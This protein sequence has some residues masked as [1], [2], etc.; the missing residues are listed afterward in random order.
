MDQHPPFGTFTPPLFLK[1]LLFITRHTLLGRGQV[2]RKT[3]LAFKYHSFDCYDL[4]VRNYFMR[5]YPGNNTVERKLML[6]PDRYCPDEIKFLRQVFKGATA[7]EPMS[8]LDI[9]ANIGALTLPVA[10]LPNV[11]TIAVEPEPS[12]Y[13]RIK[14]NLEINQFNHVKLESIAL[15]DQEGEVDFISDQNDL[16]YSG[17]NGRW[18]KGETI[19]VKATT[20]E[21][22][23]EKH[24]LNKI[25]VLKIDVE[26]HEDQI[27][28]P[29]F[30]NCPKELWPA[31]IIIEAIEREGLPDCIEVMRKLG[32]VDHF[33]NRA[34]LCLKLV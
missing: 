15:S 31:Y 5:L 18:A 10:A 34:N 30:E 29:F 12:A 27:L 16:K 11:N 24:C 33:K 21:K 13:E 17:I 8:Y 4:P 9:G 22:L 14:F 26:G 28:L 3:W 2:R 1:F 23:I 6:R 7:S 19:K 32:Y 20:L 25:D